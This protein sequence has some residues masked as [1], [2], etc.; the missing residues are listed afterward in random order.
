M[1]RPDGL[2]VKLRVGIG[3]H[4]VKHEKNSFAPPAGGDGEIVFVETMFIPGVRQILVVSQCAEALHVPLRRHGKVGP[5]T[6]ICA[7]GAEKFPRH[8]VVFAV[9]GE[10]LAVGFLRASADA[11][12]ERKKN[13]RQEM[14][15]SE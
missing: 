1:N 6:G 15:K 13:R 8:G 12:R 7:A 3:Q 11:E 2:A 5:E 4:A 14:T 10:K 9:T